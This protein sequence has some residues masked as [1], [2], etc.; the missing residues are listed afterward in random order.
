MSSQESNRNRNT[1]RALAGIALTLV[2]GGVAAIDH[3]AFGTSTLPDGTSLHD[4]EQAV[5]TEAE[6][7]AITN[8]LGDVATNH[9][10]GQPEIV[11]LPQPVNAAAPE[12]N[13]G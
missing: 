9:T 1:R 5:R 2:L 12:Q 3:E 6:L 10:V 13:H 8:G 4:L 11:P 7:T